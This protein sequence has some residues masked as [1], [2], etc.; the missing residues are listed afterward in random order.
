MEHMGEI[1]FEIAAKPML[2]FKIVVLTSQITASAVEMMTLA[3]KGRSK[4]LFVGEPTAGPT[5]MNITFSL[6]KN[7]L[8]IAA[9]IIADRK[10]RIYRGNVFQMLK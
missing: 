9:S 2:N 8:A 7:T 5:T 6:D 4:T 3:L 10:G 1:R